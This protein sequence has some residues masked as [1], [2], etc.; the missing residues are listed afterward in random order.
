[1]QRIAPPIRTHDRGD[2][3]GNLQQALVFLVRARREPV[4]GMDADGWQRA[5]DTEMHEATFGGRTLGLLNELQRVLQMPVSEIIDEEQAR[6]LNQELERLGAFDAPAPEF[7]YVVR[8]QLLYRRGRFIPDAIVRAYNRELRGEDLIGEA[9]SDESGNYEI[10]YSPERFTRAKQFANLQVRA[11]ERA[12]L[13]TGEVR[14]T[15]LAESPIRPNAG[16]IEK[17]RLQVDGGLERRWSEFE[18]LQAEIQPLLGTMGVHEL[19]ETREQ[20]DI[21]LLAAEL[22]QNVDRV[23]AFAV[24]HKMAA[25]TQV[26]PELYYGLLRQNQP[27]TL[28]KL[29][30]QNSVAHQVALQKSVD[31]NI[32]PGRLA[33]QVEAAPEL[34]RKQVAQYTATVDTGPQSLRTLLGGTL[35]EEELTAFV[36]AR[37]DQ[38]GSTAEF[39]NKIGA[40][41]VL[42]NK[43]QQIQ[44]DLQLA[45]LTGKHAPLLQQLQRMKNAGEFASLRDLAGFNE[46]RWAQVVQQQ[47]VPEEQLFPP[48]IPPELKKEDKVRVYAQTM[49]RIMEDSFPTETLAHRLAQDER[50][51]PQVRQFFGNVLDSAPEFDLSSTDVRK[52][53][54]QKPDLIANIAEPEPVLKKVQGM[55]RLTR[56]GRVD[57]VRTLS[58]AGLDSSLAI[59]SI[60]R[61]AF[62]KQFG[63]ALG[64]ARTR[65]IHD[66][67]K[68]TTATIL[69][70]FTN[71]SPLFNDLHLRVLVTPTKQDIPNLETLFGALDLCACDQCRSVYGPAAYFAELL[72]FLAERK[73]AVGTAL[74]GLFKRRADLA[75]V[76]LSCENTN[77]VVPYLDLVM[78]ILENEIAPFKPFA[79]PAGVAAELDAETLSADLR[80]AFDAESR[81]LGPDYKVIVGEKG[82]RWRLS[83]GRIGYTIGK[84]GGELRVLASGYQTYGT[85]DEINANSQHINEAAYE[86]L[87]KTVCG[88]ALPLDLWWEEA[89]AYLPPLGAERHDLMRACYRGAAESVTDADIAAEYLGIPTLERELVP[90][91]EWEFW[92][93]LEQNNR[94]RRYDAAAAGADKFV[95]S[96]LAWDMALRQVRVLLESGGLSYKE[97]I[98]VLQ[99]KFVNPDGAIRIE[100]ADPL[101]LA[102]CDTSK[103]VLTDALDRPALQRARQFL[104][105]WRRLA[106]SA[107]DLDRALMLFGLDGTLLVKLAHTKQTSAALGLEV[108]QVLSLWSNLDTEGE[109]ALYPRLFLNASLLKPVD[110]AFRLQGG[111]LAIV[112]EDAAEAK[113]SRHLPA[114]A[115]ALSLPASELASLAENALADDTLD[116]ANLS[117]L[118]RHALLARG[119]QLSVADVLALQ[120]IAGIDP[121]DAGHTEDALQ[122]S[123]LAGRI[124][125]AG[126]SVA[127]LDY[128][129]RHRATAESGLMPDEASIASILADIRTEL[130]RIYSDTQNRDDPDGELLRKSLAQIRVPD[131][132]VGNVVDTLLGRI[133]YEAPVDPLPAV[134]P[135]IP[136]PLKTRVTL[137]KAAKTL[138]ST[139]TLTLLERQSLEGASN[140]AQFRGALTRVFDAP[141]LFLAQKLK[142]FAYPM[143]STALPGLPGGVVLPGEMR[144]RIFHDGPA[145]QLRFAGLMLETEKARLDGL[146]NDAAYRTAVQALFDAG[147]AHVPPSEETFVTAADA[148]A[149]F[150]TDRPPE[151]RFAVLLTK[152]LAYL[153]G[154]MGRNAVIQHLAEVLAL[155]TR[156]VEALLMRV[157]HS[158]ANPA[159]PAFNDFIAAP[160]AR[161]D[162]GVEIT[163]TAFADLF[164][165]ALRLQKAAWL[166]S[167]LK[168]THRQV[169]ALETYGADVTLRPIPWTHGA[170]KASWLNLNDLPVERRDEAR[171]SCAGL[172]RILDL[173]DLRTSLPR[174]EVLL[175]DL[176]TLARKPGVTADELAARLTL[177]TAWDRAEIDFL[178]GA[179]G[180]KPTLPDAFRDEAFL[181]QLQSA[182]RQL[183]R[184]GTTAANAFA[185]SAAKLTA[186]DARRIRQ[187]L[188]SKYDET[189]WSAAVK[190]LA[191]R[192]RVRRRD[193]LVAHLLARRSAAGDRVWDNAD[194]LYASFL[195]DVSMDACMA[196]SRIKQAISS[197]QL[198]IQRCRMNLEAERGVIA[199]EVADPGWRL[200]QSIKSYRLWEADR[201]VFLYPENVLEPALLNDKSPFFRE[202]ESTLMQGDVDAAAVEDAYIAYLEKLDAV[203]RLE[204]VGMYFEAAA[205]GKP[206]TVHVFGRTHGSPPVYYYRQQ[207]GGV[208]WTAWERVDADIGDAPILPLI[209]NRRL[210]LF[211]VTPRVETEE[212]TNLE[213]PQPAKKYFSLQLAWS[214]RKRGKWL[215]KKMADESLRVRS[216]V[217]VTGRGDEERS[218]HTLRAQIEGAG[219]RIWYEYDDPNEATR[220]QTGYGATKTTSRYAQVEGW[221][222]SSCNGPMEKFQRDIYW[223][224]EPYGTYPRGMQFV[225]GLTTSM[226]IPIPVAG[227]GFNLLWIPTLVQSPLYLPREDNAHEDIALGATPGSFS[228]LYAHQD[229]KITGNRPFFYQDDLRTFYVVPSTET[230]TEWI[231]RWSQAGPDVFD[232]DKLHLYYYQPEGKRDRLGP[233]ERLKTRDYLPTELAR[234]QVRKEASLLQAQPLAAPAA[235]PAANL[236]PVVASSRNTKYIVDKGERQRLSVSDYVIDDRVFGNFQFVPVT[237]Q[238]RRYQFCAHYHPFVP[239]FIEELNRIGVPRLFDRSLQS[240]A[241]VDFKTRYAPTVLVKADS[242]P[243]EDV[244]FS[245]AGAYSPVQLGAVLPRAAAA[246]PSG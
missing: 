48:G 133:V 67:A 163:A 74:D 230:T 147:A 20:P 184:L 143:F 234:T 5:L 39:W 205:G 9:V 15:L 130:Q 207:L 92:G 107:H 24:A 174:G 209:W 101:D 121:F 81:P 183:K 237:K 191:D 242:L 186:D 190:P 232:I 91:G 6:R 151:A 72:A 188:R 104:R 117:T 170:V 45:A 23:A 114:I 54:A 166:V 62:Q 49:A 36:T 138:R 238:E 38:Q 135:V 227:G 144:S 126:L 87:R 193:A 136:A 196:T 102:T 189:S 66:G 1:M 175:D 165:T 73:Q 180:F 89:R 160:F 153:Q 22:G 127:E 229:G 83:D 52:L 124:R 13:A 162:S 96:N 21:S 31:N 51:A 239:K 155:D 226:L 179:E 69:N 139:G 61:I 245:Y 208:R 241:T 233:V 119:T 220:T 172:L 169:S 12:Q 192:L 123:R 221:Y 2:A 154:Q 171:A 14:E 34:L 97:L 216:K 76:E 129:L 197:V 131:T 204:I 82:V 94:V 29:L 203:G 120:E 58:A 235:A 134:D 47:Q 217:G 88:P 40:D 176:F 164:K 177:G 86:E 28:A 53:V 41:P 10:F 194:D 156:I 50:H 75:E 90:G 132:L 55:Q 198:Y 148:A 168:L 106:W 19:T 149:I 26:A 84:A 43:S 218:R 113:I 108:R 244:D 118:Y 212:A 152:L 222:F 157:I 4:G 7:Q 122:F 60:D 195:I 161:S 77:T 78:E 231:N 3:V 103:L 236:S 44:L 150:D 56:L 145:K 142:A 32:I 173:K 80:N 46:E 99:T 246:S 18:E 95:V 202:L 68:Q 71:F 213:S 219:L 128:L 243:I 167:R 85:T 30:S 17:V 159:V 33:A 141:R 8:G 137:D 59:A 240:L 225:E 37:A 35:S 182:F 214:E 187:A 27:S 201:K 178:L 57:E 112:A 25:R 206:D 211:W 16:P 42:G 105:L 146:S 79:L 109:D 223:I 65:A 115:A 181:S 64:E 224:Y 70:Y 200:V 110:A 63:P 158:A 125:D 185:W 116:L 93:L 210:F 215:A 228:L 140:D 11:F 98:Q 111:E 199:D 100:S